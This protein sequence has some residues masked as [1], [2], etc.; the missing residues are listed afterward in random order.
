M[1]DGP[2]GAS[3][4]PQAALR[5][6]DRAYGMELGEFILDGRQRDCE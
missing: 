1:H 4:R 5:I 6:A 3:S 2:N